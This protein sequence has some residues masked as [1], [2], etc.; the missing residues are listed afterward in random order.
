MSEAE[1]APPPISG[2]G[3]SEGWEASKSNVEKIFDIFSQQDGALAGRAWKTL[4]ELA[5]IQP[6]MYERFA[7]FLVSTYVI[8]GG[9]NRGKPLAGTTA[10][11]YLGT[12]INLAKTKYGATASDPAKIFFQC[13]DAS[14][15][16]EQTKWLS[17]VKSNIVREYV[18]R[19][20][21]EGESIDQSESPLYP[22]DVSKIN[23]GYALIGGREEAKRKLAI[24]VLHMAVGRAGET[25]AMSYNLLEFDNNFECAV[26]RG[27][28]IKTS[29]PKM[30]VMLTAKDRHLDFY[31]NWGDYMAL[32]QMGSSTPG[33]PDFMIVD[34]VDGCAKKIGGYLKAMSASAVGGAA[35]TYEKVA[36]EGLPERISAGSIRPGGIN[37]MFGKVPSDMMAANTGHDMCKTSALFEYVDPEVASCVP[38]AIAR[39]PRRSRSPAA[40]ASTSTAAPSTSTAP[41]TAIAHGDIAGMTSAEAEEASRQAGYSPGVLDDEDESPRKRGRGVAAAISSVFFGR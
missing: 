8:S 36:V 40:A 20:S 41:P 13:L 21:A 4:D 1:A 17:R 28:Q 18:A 22:V 33:D 25:G 15:H 3:E 35:K 16:S 11:N 9:Q 34:L 32:H 38:G 6:A 27:T 37:A 2:R 39:S 23:R 24:I 26:V 19:M 29:K 12:L 31:L 10:S 14:S 30:I 5:V 7:R